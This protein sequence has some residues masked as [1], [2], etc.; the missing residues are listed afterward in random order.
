MS[1][2]SD[3]D[4]ALVDGKMPDFDSL[5]I[6][7]LKR[8]AE[9]GIHQD[10]FSDIKAAFI[11]QRAHFRLS[12][13]YL[14]QLLDEIAPLFPDVAFDARGLGECFR[15]TWIAEYRNGQRQYTQGPWDDD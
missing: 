10:V 13:V 11:N 9:D 6:R 8:L 1:F 15:E 5:R 3:L 4:I 14:L 7:V 12:S 2:D